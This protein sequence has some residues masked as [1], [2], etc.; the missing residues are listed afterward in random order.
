MSPTDTVL[1]GLIILLGG[2]LLA[3]VGWGFRN[4][5][6]RLDRVESWTQ[7]TCRHLAVIRYRLKIE[8]EHA[9][10]TDSP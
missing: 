6:A 1:L 9:N 8:A 2:S 10:Q 7:A 5:A 3:V 4:L